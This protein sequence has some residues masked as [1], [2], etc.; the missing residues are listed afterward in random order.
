ME[1]GV[2]IPNVSDNLRFAELIGTCWLTVINLRVSLKKTPH[3]NTVMC[4]P[5]KFRGHT[6]KHYRCTTLGNSEVTPPNTVV[7]CPWKFRGHT[8][9]ET[10]SCFVSLK[11]DFLT[12]A[13][14][15]GKA[16]INHLHFIAR[17]VKEGPPTIS[18]QN[19]S[20]NIFPHSYQF[21][22]KLAQF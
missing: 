7:C 12:F 11:Y 10:H 21:N 20:I 3:G 22:N 8:H 19:F 14:A 6:P 9:M 2:T 18:K 13:L 1:A 16:R 17:K 15:F 5:W 4:C